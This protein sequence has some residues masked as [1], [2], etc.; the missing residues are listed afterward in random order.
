MTVVDRDL[1]QIPP[2]ELLKVRARMTIIDG[3]P[4]HEPGGR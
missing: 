4:E 1:F 3:E 2:D